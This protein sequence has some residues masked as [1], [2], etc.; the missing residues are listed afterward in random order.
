VLWSNKRV[1]KN[2]Y[3]KIKKMTTL[4]FDPYEVESVET[5]EEADEISD[6]YAPMVQASYMY[7]GGGREKTQAFLDKFYTGV[8]I[9]DELS[10]R[11]NL[12]MRNEGTNDA[13]VSVPGT[14]GVGD[15]VSTWP[16][17][18]SGQQAA[19]VTALTSPVG[20]VNQLI[21]RGAVS[22]AAA[23]SDRQSFAERVETTRKTLDSIYGKY[24]ETDTLLLGHSMGGAVARTVAQQEDLS[25]IIFNSAVGRSDV[26][27]NNRR[28]N[29]EVRIRKDVVSATMHNK[30]REFSL[31]RGYS[32]FGSIQAHDLTN[33]VS[34]KPRYNQLLT[35]TAPIV[36]YDPFYEPPKRGRRAEK[37]AVSVVSDFY[38][39]RCVARGK[40][41]CLKIRQIT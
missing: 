9:D 36:R 30:K 41:R 27:Q 12:V 20:F 29:I 25:S 34:D 35:D 1:K 38:E 40:K 2:Q 17:I 21:G 11:E 8:T 18:M 24:G 22:A 19:A 4:D 14:T 26:S 33:F 28:R 39:E 15:A 6:R 37:Y 23:L 10:S 32:V 5:N 7:E 3:K 13:F 31:D 16:A